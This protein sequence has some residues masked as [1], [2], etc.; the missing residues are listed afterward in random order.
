MTGIYA[1]TGGSGGASD[2]SPSGGASTDN[3]FASGGTGGADAAKEPTSGSTSNVGAPSSD[4]GGAASSPGGPSAC[5]VAASEHVS[6]TCAEC[7]CSRSGA[8]RSRVASCGASCWDLLACVDVLCGGRTDDTDCIVQSCDLSDTDAATRASSC[9]SGCSEVCAADLEAIASPSDGGTPPG[10][11]GGVAGATCPGEV[12]GLTA[13]APTASIAGSTAG[14]GDDYQSYCVKDETGGNEA[15]YAVSVEQA[16]TLTVDV[17]TTSGTQDPVLYVESSCGQEPT[18]IACTDRLGASEQMALAVDGPGT[19]YVFVEDRA[20]SAG[21]FTVD[22][23]IAAAACGDGA[24]NPGEA[25]DFGDVSPGDGCDASCQL[26]APTDASNVCPGEVGTLVAGTPQTVSSFTVGYSDSYDAPCGAETG[27]PDRVFAFNPQQDGT[28]TASLTSSFDGVLSIYE[29]CNVPNLFDLRLCSDAPRAS[30]D[31]S[32]S[33]DV[34]G[35]AQYFVVVDGYRA[36]SMGTFD[37]TVELV[38]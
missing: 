25:C 27:A 19:F 32:V 8:C 36:S 12:V 5:V 17:A 31:E 9:V 7:A 24:V 16:G 11:G 34:V 4:F 1:C 20:D 13:A 29:T 35:G 37:L 26:E 30:A 2:G 21:A 38:P 18:T 14:L 28:L 33:V 23:G 10:D 3:G 15:V 22:F 6:L